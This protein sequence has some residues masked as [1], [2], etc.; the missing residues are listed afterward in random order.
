MRTLIKARDGGTCTCGCKGD[1]PWHDTHY[2]RVVR[3]I[4]ETRKDLGNGRFSVAVGT[5]RFPWGVE[6]VRRVVRVLDGK[7]YI[8]GW[9]IVK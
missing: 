9:E 4:T 8:V 6:T 5:A 7:E 3:G 2:R 1:D